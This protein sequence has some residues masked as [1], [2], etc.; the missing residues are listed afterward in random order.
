MIGCDNPDYK[1]ECFHVS[2]L[3]LI[4]IPKVNG[5]ILTVNIT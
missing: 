4:S 3:K 1:I 5:I 2:C